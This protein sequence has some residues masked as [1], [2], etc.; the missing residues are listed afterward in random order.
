MR[1]LYLG[2]NRVGWK[3]LEWLREQGETVV[4]LVVHP[5]EEAR[6]R[7]EIL[8][9]AAL[10]PD[11][12]FDGSRLG[13]TEVLR[14]IAA[15]NADL[16]VSAFFG[17]ILRKEFLDI[18]PKGVINLHP[19]YLPF[20]RGAHPNVW[21]IIEGTP[22]GVTLHYIDE[23]VD[24]GDVIARRRITIEPVDT[25]ETLYRKLERACLDLFRSTWPGIRSGDAPRE[26][27]SAAEGN[28]HRIQDI[29]KTDEIDLNRTYKARELID[30]IRARTFPPHAGTYF[31]DGGKKVY[32][33]LHLEPEETQS[34]K[35]K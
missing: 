27:Q 22:A 20:N 24:T 32:L 26:P 13:E 17:Y 16:A 2:N 30:L 15:L 29:E 1:I 10:P 35:E 6:Y 21:S 31:R 18:F 14:A 23:G 4:G 11:K 19:A 25:G 8:N 7:D 33:R 12:V 3:V 9:A 28:S 5:P 34:D